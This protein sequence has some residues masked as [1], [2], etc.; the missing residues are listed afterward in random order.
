[1]DDFAGYGAIE[2]IYEGARSVAYRARRLADDRPV[3]LKVGHASHST[4]DEAL[5]RLRHELAVLSTIKSERVNRAHEVTTIGKD[6]VLVVDDFGGESLERYLARGRFT[7]ADAL[8]LAIGVVAA[9]RDVHAAGFIHRDIAPNNIVYNAATGQI[10]LIDFDIATAWRTDHQ[11]FG[12][13]SQLEGTLR[14]MAPEQTGRM[15]RAI[16]NRADLYAF[17]G[18]LFELL[19]GQLPFAET[20]LLAIVHAHLAVRPPSPDTIDRAIP[21]AVA[22]IV[23]KLLAKQPEDRYQTAEGLLADLRTCLEQLSTTGTVPSFPLGRDDIAKRFELPTRPYG[24]AAEIAVLTNAFER[25]ATGSVEAVLVA[26]RSGVGKTTVARELFP[27]VT[28]ARGYFLSGKFDQLRGDAPFAALVA[29]FDELIHLLLTESEDE[30]ARWREL[31]TA[32]VGP[33]GQ[34]VIDAIPALARV[35]GPQHPVVALDAASTQSRFNQTLQKLIQVFARRRHP[36]VLFLDDMQWA[37]PESL[38]LLKLV[39]LSDATESLLLIEAYR[40]NEVGEG[41]PVMAAARELRRRRHVT[42]LELAPLPASQI[43][44]MIA[45]TLHREVD[46]IGPLARLVCRKT[47]GNPFFVRQLLHALHD[48]GHIVF[49]AA[50]RRFTFDA[51]SIERAPITENVADLLA[52]SLR[53]LPAPTRRV[54]AIAAAIGNRFELELVARVAGLSAVAVQAELAAALDQELVVPLSELEYVAAPDGGGLAFRRLRFQHDRIQAAAYALM[55]P[56]EAQRTHLEIGERFAPEAEHVFDAVSHLNRALPLITAP[57]PLARL[58]L[59]AARKAFGS[60]AYG[61]AIECLQIAVERLDWRADY[62]AQLEAH[63]MLAECRYIAGDVRRALAVLDV[64]TAHAQAN[65]DR[66]E[67]DALRT[68]FHT[69]AN[70]L[71]AALRAV[72]LATPPLGLEL[73]GDPIELIAATRTTTATI[74]RRIGD[75][76]P[77]Q[78]IDLP[79]MT[80]PDTLALVAILRSAAPAAFQTEPALAAFLTAQIVLLSLDRGNCA[81]SAQAYCSFAGILH[82]AELHALAYR[83]GQLGVDLNRRLDDRASAPAVHFVFALSAAPWKGSIA[84]AIAS[85]REAARGARALCNHVIAGNAAGQEIAMRVFQGA[86]P[87]AEICHDARI[88]RQQCAEVGDIAAERLISWQINRLR[89]LMGELESFNAEDSD[90]Q[91][92]LLATREE[93]NSA[94]QFFLL[95]LLVDLAWA[96]GDEATALELAVTTQDLA[97]RA[98]RMLPLV[99]LQFH[100]CLAAIAMLRRRPGMRHEL[101]PIIETNA[102]ALE[103][104]AI[105]CPANFEARYLLVEAERAALVEDLAATLTLYDRAT[106]SA[107]RHG[108]RRIEAMCHELHARCWT[109][110]GKHELAAVYLVRARTLYGQLGAHRNV[111]II[112]AR[113]PTLTRAAPALRISSTVTATAA[114][115]VLDAAAIAKATRAISGELE[116][117][118]LLERMLDIIFEHAG[119]S[120]GAIVLEAERGLQ[121]AAARIDGAAQISTVGEPLVG[122][123]LPRALIHYVQ[124]TD[125][126]VVLDD[127]IGDK[128]FGN[129]DY[130]RSRLPKSVLSMPIRH[131]DRALGV[132]YLENTLASGAFTQTRLDALTLLVSQLA[133]SLENARLFA[134]Q[135]VHAEAISHANEVLR[136]EIAVREQIEGELAQYRGHLEDLIAART[137]EL[138][139]ANQKLRDAAEARERIE[140]ELRLAQKLESVGRLASGIAHEINTPVQF[141]SDNV[142]FVRDAMPSLVATIAAYRDLATALVTDGDAAAARAA[143]AAIAADEDVD[144][145]LSHGPE[146]LEAALIGLARVAAIVRSM[147]DFAHPDRDEKTPVDLNRAVESTLMI[148]ANECKYVADVETALEAL[149]L[150]RCNGGEINQAILNLVVNA[151][152]AIRDVVS[153]TGGKGRI[154]VATRRDGNEVEIAI[155]D[156]GTGIPQAIRDKIYDPFFTTKEVGRGTGQGLAI[157]RSVIVDKHGGSLRFETADG[158]GTTFFLRLPIG[159]A[160]EAAA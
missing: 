21:P 79:A 128:R 151:A 54:L 112:E 110:R 20:D 131:K 59:A 33:N 48:A 6:A 46:A 134:A 40:D 100:H 102:A 99:E 8:G 71:K 36:L 125:A 67:L 91:V 118:K 39:M 97:A 127:A 138:T 76:S 85:M 119:A 86:E 157:V 109:A 121:V 24:R 23:M 63:R 120:G 114:N 18:T 129:D 2:R 50:A 35:I 73:P 153:K 11:G 28:R 74:L 43:A 41:H 51:L 158:A 64:A 15:N 160:L 3:I 104:W 98:P 32:A 88:Y 115:E 95:A 60:A 53:K 123:A 80:D 152:H 17:G 75:R 47:D 106:A 49:D 69:H 10:R 144:Y 81:A 156:T 136:S 103:H 13:P 147:K 58:N 16:D 5:A 108:Q 84:E 90:S 62:R 150:V 38:H 45:D 149:P 83:F 29:A 31:I 55:T 122:A 145:A 140:D 1:M 56:D 7:L 77:E 130:I 12:A 143:A 70:D 19:T 94:H 126:V 148:A 132:L 61:P 133:V 82:G 96:I 72:R 92:S 111:R 57:G 37:D 78:L 65:H 26:G 141:V 9:L 135:R 117:A 42:R 154:R 159:D 101:E 105:E 87:L 137:Q 14:Y 52:D 113:Q 116:I 66:G 44:A 146:A 4:L 124:R 89:V 93:A 34:V 68:T 139:L 107:L 30:L 22:A 142:T 155:S 27:L 25:V